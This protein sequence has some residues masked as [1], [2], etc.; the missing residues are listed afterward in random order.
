MNRYLFIDRD[1][2]INRDRPSYIT[3]WEEFEF[4]PGSLEALARLTT[5]GFSIII[6]TNQSAIG[7]KMMPPA[8][9]ERIFAGMRRSVEAK[10]GYILD[11]FHCPHLPGDECDCRKPGTGLIRK[12]SGK[13]AINP[14]E[15]GFIGDSAK[16]IL[17]ARAAGCAFAVLVE[18][19]S[20]TAEAK[21]ELIAQGIWP[22]HVAKDLAAAA[23]WIISNQTR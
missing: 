8:E 18:S 20:H 19:G 10:G 13:Y 2:V 11:I 23:N 14:A 1:G 21:T 12:A 4:L 16:D 5:A 6:I 17:C 7:R 3:C 22:D 15:T 9:L